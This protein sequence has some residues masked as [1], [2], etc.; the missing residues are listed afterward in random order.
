MHGPFFQ[1][2]AVMRCIV[3]RPQREHQN[4]PVG[5]GAWPGASSRSACVFFKFPQL[6]CLAPCDHMGLFWPY[7][8][9]MSIT[10][11][12]VLSV[13]LSFPRDYGIASGA[14]PPERFFIPDV[15]PSLAFRGRCR[16]ASVPMFSRASAQRAPEKKILISSLYLSRLVFLP[17]AQ[18][19]VS[20]ATSLRFLLRHFSIA[21]LANHPVSSAITPSSSAF[22]FLR[23]P[24][25][26]PQRE[27]YVS[28]LCEHFSRTGAFECGFC[29]P[30]RA[31][32]DLQTLL[33]PRTPCML[34]DSILRDFF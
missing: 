16:P 10:R 19:G 30:S 14:R 4:C 23:V 28:F 7:S 12:S 32:R 27:H 13:C 9:H 17:S 34:R 8:Y 2:F 6:P 1:P 24:S 3:D 29:P 25:L 21:T 22:Q 15:F 18:V 31:L 11:L 20:P 26:N 33:P 5:G